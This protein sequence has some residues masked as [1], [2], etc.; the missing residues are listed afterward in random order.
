MKLIIGLGNPEKKYEKT[1][2][3]TGF[4]AIDRLAGEW[5]EKPKFHGLVSE[6]T[7]DGE[8]IIFYKPTTYYN[9][10]GIGARSVKD[11][12][13]LDNNDILVIHDE[14]ALPFGTVRSRVGGSDAGNNGIKSLNA[15]LGED[16]ARVRV[17]I[18]QEDRHEND[19]NFVLSGFN[20]SE[21]DSLPHV[22]DLVDK[23]VHE[24]IS[25]N[26][27]HISRKI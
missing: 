21:S 15:H 1:R 7:V 2:H 24:F 20:K 5:Q 3:N 27:E 26:L 23:L 16:Y 10:S 25:G 6:K 14:L 22:L 17:G 18:G 13:K 11:F 9:D 19:I 12:Y 4:M 8:K